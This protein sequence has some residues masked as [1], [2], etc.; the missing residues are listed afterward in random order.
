MDDLPLE[1]AS[2]LQHCF[3]DIDD[4][5]RVIIQRT[6]FPYTQYRDSR[7]LKETIDACSAST[8]AIVAIIQE[9]TAI[10]PNFQ[11]NQPSLYFDLKRM[12]FQ[13]AIRD[14]N[15]DRAMVIAK[16]DLATMSLRYPEF[17]EPFKEAALGL[18]IPATQKS[19]SIRHLADKI[20][21]ALCASQNIPAPRLVAIV[22][23]LLHIHRIWF[24]QQCMDDRYNLIRF[25]DLR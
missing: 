4:Q 12:E 2:R 23:G 9:I 25:I 5:K 20:D 3:N 14:E 17:V 22:Q 7:K 18:V 11:Q 1:F 24:Q 21:L 6:R 13:A 10:D 15:I 8:P 19:P 16:H